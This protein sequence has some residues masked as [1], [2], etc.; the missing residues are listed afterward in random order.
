[1]DYKRIIKNPKV[2][3]KILDFLSFVP[4]EIMLKIQYKIKLRR[5]LNL[6]QPKRFTEKIQWYKLNYRDPI[7]KQS[8][9]KYEVRKHIKD[10][11][12]TN[13]LTDLY[14]VVDDTQNI[15]FEKLPESFVMKS[16]NGGGGLN[17]LICNNKS[18]FDY[19]KYLPIMNNWL[20][21]KDKKSGEEKWVY[22]GL[23][24]RIIIEE[25][26]IDNH[27]DNVK[28]INDYKFLCFNGKPQYI[29]FDIDRYTNH[30]R[31]IYDIDWNYLNIST[32]V[33]P[34]G[35]IFPKP[36]GLKEMIEIAKILS[37]DF[38]FVR[39]DLYYVNNKVYFGELTFFPWSGY[40]QFQP[41]YFD[42]ELGKKFNLPNT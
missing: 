34:E 24:P 22:N 38:P 17:V 25:L 19:N 32:D 37:E 10:K 4:D 30:K 2:R 31:N 3:Y 18:T 14:Q 40:V 12:L 15:N 21:K 7:M 5:N 33:K 1:M 28:G 26:L 42:Y 27:K 9:D 29:I 23:K 11:G 8:V 13:I 39:V 36:K 41:D 35:D 16:T 6:N 20:V